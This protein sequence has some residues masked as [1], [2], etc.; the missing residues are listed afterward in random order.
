M[1]KMKWNGKFLCLCLLLAALAI[2]ASAAE[3]TE[4]FAGGSGAENRYLAAG[5]TYMSKVRSY[6]D[7]HFKLVLNAIEGGDTQQMAELTCDIDLKAE[8]T[9]ENPNNVIPTA[10]GNAAVEN[11]EL[12][13]ALP[14]RSFNV[15]RLGK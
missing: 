15:I 12:K 11:G 4:H 1:G 5:T 10:D 8:N 3:D 7:T 9:E 13:A 2:S 6:L 14:A